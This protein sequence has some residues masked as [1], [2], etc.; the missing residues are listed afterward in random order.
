VTSRRWT[1]LIIALIALLLLAGRVVTSIYAD[2]H[3]YASLGAGH[4]WRTKA[5][6]IFILRGASG[7]AATLFLFFNL[8]AVA[9]SI[10]K[11]ILPRRVANIEIGEEVPRRYL[12]LLAAAVAVLLG[13]LSTIPLDDWTTV[14]ASYLGA[15]FGERDPYH[16]LDLGFYVYSLPLERSLYFWSLVVVL[17]VTAVVIF[18]YA[19]TPSLRWERGTLYVSNYVRRHLMVLGSALM[20]LLAW[21]DRLDAYTV[22]LRG[23]GA[24]GAFTYADHHAAIPVN[25]ALAL[26]TCAAAAVVL[27]FGWTGQLRA[28]FIAVTTVIAAS[29]LLKQLAPVVVRRGAAER[30]DE[31]RERPYLATR[32]EYT[33]RAFDI[34]R[35]LRPD[36]RVSFPRLIDAA[37]WVAAWDPAALARAM[38]H[39]R[40]HPRESG[41]GISPSGLLSVVPL[42]AAGPE[43][44]DPAQDNWSIARVSSTNTDAHGD[45]V[46]LTVVGTPARE[47]EHLDPVL[48]F[49]GASGYLL[50]RDTAGRIPAPSL[51]GA[52]SRIAHAW[53][54]Q[55]FRLLASDGIGRGA[56]R[57]LTHRDVRE[58][59]A[60]LVPFLRQ[61]DDIVPAYVPDTLYW[62]VE[63]YTVSTSYPLS[64]R[65]S[66]TDDGDG[67]T[68]AHHAGS[69]F[70]NA[71]TGHVLIAVDSARD[72]IL[73]TWTRA[74]PEL[75]V[76]WSSVPP[77]LAAQ[78]AP[79]SSLGRAQASVL[80][81]FG[82]RGEML[83]GNH[84]P[85]HNDPD[86]VFWHTPAPL[87][88]LPFAESRSLAWSEPV[89]DN[90]DRAVGLLIATG[91]P[92]HSS[93]W[94]ALPAPG[95]RWSSVFD[96]LHRTL[97]SV[98]IPRNTQLLHGAIRSVPVGDDIAFMQSAYI[99]STEGI[100]LARVAVTIGDQVV[101]GRSLGDALGVSSAAD[102]ASHPLSAGDFRT[103]VQQLYD[104]MRVALQHN[105]LAAFGRAYEALGAVLAQQGRQP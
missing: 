102:S 10:A 24:D 54:L 25:I 65:I 22:L 19:L 1:L 45:P 72:A 87:M 14:A 5:I 17:L 68:Y 44:S 66:F 56:D 96:A 103:R 6:S 78:A 92:A 29:L 40:E 60:M 62:S 93:Y 83:P 79:A 4:L 58:R 18:A 43:E 32:A 47:D 20:L 61:G 39:E 64:A 27:Y 51:G 38:T 46:R 85:V 8:S 63:L 82:A 33:R 70:V 16:E 21:S 12:I 75:F 28:A 94:L 74:F 30:A 37:R 77:A 81:R 42:R 41:W 76:A 84:L 23:S 31:T 100:T 48:I 90:T 69:A 67:V 3:W 9:N 98:P 86:S 73:T 55:D 11:L 49:P 97:D 59:V 89:L 2:Y 52:G 95:A 104:Q 35:V 88:A 57:L 15:P 26:L 50:L 36:R 34:D 13:V 80:A 71:E 91:G 105:D 99:S 101:S 53:S 7:F